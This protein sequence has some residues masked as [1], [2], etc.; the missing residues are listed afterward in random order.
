MSVGLPF[1]AVAGLL[2]AGSASVALHGS[3]AD[4]ASSRVSVPAVA[5]ASPA[6]TSADSTRA[7]DAKHVI[8]FQENGRY[9]GWPA[10]QGA[11]VWGNEILVGFDDGEFNT[12]QKGHTLTRTVSPKQRLARSR[13]GGETWTITE[14]PDLELP[15]DVGYQGSYPPGKGRPLGDLPGSIDFTHPDFAFTARM[16]KNPGVSR[17]YY[18]HDRGKTWKGPYRLPN[19]GRSGTAARTDYVVN[20]KHDLTLFTTLAK[21]DGKEGRPAMVRTRDGGKTWTLESLIGQEP[22]ADD[23]AIMPSTVQIGDSTFLTAVRHK[24]R[25]EL[26][27]SGDGGKSWNL[28]QTVYN[29]RGNPASLIRLRDGRLVLTYGFRGEPYGIRARVSKDD[30]GNWSDE[31]ILRDDGGNDDLGYPRSVQRADGKVVTMY[32]YNTDKTRERFIAATIWTP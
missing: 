28:S 14:P 17:F 31:V 8:V 26:F 5:A 30:G 27:R 9:G 24:G 25:L 16:T 19:F 3:S 22:A 20:G 23:Y 12:Q 6:S 32:Y 10:N 13:D 4:D 15:S 29:G 1:C 2:V 18:S 7:A 21:E 11:W